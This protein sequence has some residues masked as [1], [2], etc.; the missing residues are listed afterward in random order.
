MDIVTIAISCM[1]GF[2][3]GSVFIIF[4]VLI[5]PKIGDDDEEYKGYRKEE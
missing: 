3:I 4:L 2:L 5:A 1:A